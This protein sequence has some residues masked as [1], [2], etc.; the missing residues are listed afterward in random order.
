MEFYADEIDK[1]VMILAA[2][3]GLNS[4]TAAQFVT[5]I[6]HL[7]DAGLTK[8]II[9]CSRLTHVSSHGLGVLVRLHQRMK[10]RGGEVKLCSVK[11]IVPQIL[12]V[13]RL[14]SMIEFYPD[15]NRARLAFRPRAEPPAAR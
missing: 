6:E 3:G 14:D 12:Q 5:E 1:D 15:V 4:D 2:D 7:V 10:G 11:G 9:D 13:T 8:L